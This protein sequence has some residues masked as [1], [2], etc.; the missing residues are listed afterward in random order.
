VGDK[1]MLRQVI[2]K[3]FGERVSNPH[4]VTPERVRHFFEWS[5][6]SMQT[7]IGKD[8]PDVWGERLGIDVKGSRL[9]WIRHP[10]FSCI[11]LVDGRV[12][13]RYKVQTPENRG[14]PLDEL[15]SAKESE[16]AKIAALFES[17]YASCC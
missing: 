7:A 12:D 9:L 6:A 16:S 13:F 3:L 14:L 5:E 11:V 8:G 10:I 1:A 15:P 4:L 17:W 2:A